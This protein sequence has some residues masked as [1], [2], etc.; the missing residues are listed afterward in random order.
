MQE[1]ISDD[2]APPL[3]QYLSGA[4]PDPDLYSTCGFEDSLNFQPV[5][6]TQRLDTSGVQLPRF[7]EFAVRPCQVTKYLQTCIAGIIPRDLLGSRE[8]ARII[9]SGQ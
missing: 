8:N 3:T 5:S 6:S 7:V 1:S 2:S 4:M 9:N